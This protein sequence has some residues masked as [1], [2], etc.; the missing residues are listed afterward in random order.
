MSSL[1]RKPYDMQFPTAQTYEGA[2]VPAIGP[3]KQLRRLV[4]AC[5]LWEKNFYTD[6]KTS[7][8]LIKSLVAKVSPEYVARLALE[9]RTS[10]KLR[11]VPLL[12]C[13]ELA[14]SGKLTAA[15]LSAVIQRPDEMAEFLAIYWQEK[16][17]SLANQIKKGLASA[18]STFNEYQLAKWDKNSAAISIRD[19]MFMCHP[20]PTS[21]DQEALFKRIA[22]KQMVTPLTWETELSAGADKAATFSRLMKENK[23]GALAFLRNLRNM[24]QAGVPETLIRAYS[25]NLNVDNV[26]PFRYVAAARIVP[27]LEDMLE[28]M[29]YR[30]L[31]KVEKLP[32]KTIFLVDVSGSMFGTKVSEKSDLDR[33]DA[34]AALTMLGAETCES[35]EIY[36]FS[37]SLVRVA[38]RKG[39]ALADALKSSQNNGGTDL[40]KALAHLHS[41]YDRLII[42]TDE[43]VSAGRLAFKGKKTYL[44]N[45]GSY[46]NGINHSE[47]TTITGFSESVFTYIR[48]SE[49][50]E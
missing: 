1:N 49:K 15:V 20:K 37:N 11:H 12:L 45:V 50:T 18:F 42:V 19:I 6:G 44:L 32:G 48:E 23:L 31:G 38:P 29:M 40:A 13:R 21:V 26:L 7:A 27:Q 14:R 10:F 30:S 39:F 9:A 5:M 3:E 36:T 35:T 41:N 47:C 17:T 2:V 24:T 22:D 25:V 43:Q 4:M 33:F 46:Q 16:R 8:D 28:A 34:A